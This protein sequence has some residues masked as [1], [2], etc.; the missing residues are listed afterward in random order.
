MIRIRERFVSNIPRK[1]SEPSF[2]L[3]HACLLLL[4]SVF[5]LDELAARLPYLN[6]VFVN[7]LFRRIN[8][9]LIISAIDNNYR[10]NKVAASVDDLSTEIGH[11]RRLS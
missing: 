8:R 4:R 2:R 5:S 1:I 9:S 3:M 6:V 7:E 10:S 11:A